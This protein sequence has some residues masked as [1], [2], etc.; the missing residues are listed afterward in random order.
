MAADPT[1]T[2][3]FAF[4]KKEN[5]QYYG[6]LLD[7]R[8]AVE[9]WL[10]F[11]PQTFAHYTDHTVRHSDEI[12]AQVS[13]LLF[14]PTRK[15]PILK[16]TATE[17]YILAAAAYLHDAGMVVPDAEKIKIL[18]SDEWKVW[19]GDKGAGAKRWA[20]IEAFR[21]GEEPPDASIRNFRADVHVR[22]LI[23]EFVRPD[24]HRRAADVIAQHEVDLGL[25]AFRD[26]M[27][28]EAIAS[29][30]VGHGLRTHELEDDERYPDLNQI[31]GEDVNLRFIAIM[32]RLGD[33]LDMSYDR[34][35]PWLM[36][37][38][39]PLP[40]TSYAH[41]TQYQC[42]KQRVTSPEKIKISARPKIQK[43]HRVLQDWCQW[44]EDEVFDDD[45]SAIAHAEK[46][47][48][49]GYRAR[50]MFVQHKLGPTYRSQY[51][52]DD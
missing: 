17:A 5:A 42:I 28:R 21:N 16:L 50:V 25:F 22:Q 44:I 1:K 10:K 8:D 36:N 51:W 6:R 27:L 3:L 15:T 30:C 23:A 4:I 29:V 52:G 46:L 7:L 39:S 40:S 26:P 13:K 2:A 38:A 49:E 14:G 33:L 47:Q 24:H 37:A 43:E 31:Q 45:D 11:V 34:A 18:Q 35:C 12:V 48:S 20:E 41:W 19:V 32:L 9:G